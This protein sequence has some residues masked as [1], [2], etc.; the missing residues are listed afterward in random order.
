[1]KKNEW[2]LYDTLGF[3]NFT[4]YELKAMRVCRGFTLAQAAKQ[5]DCPR[6]V[7]ESFENCRIKK[8]PEFIVDRCI[9]KLG[10]QKNHITQIRKILKGELNSFTENR[11]IPTSIKEK[12][13]EQYGNK[14]A[15]CGSEKSLH[16][17]HKEHYADGG[18]NT[19]DNLILLCAS[20]HAKQHKGETPYFLLKAIAKEDKQ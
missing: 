2:Q 6:S 20:C 14:C 13:R 8:V 18:Q 7:L 15:L 4:G 9:H 5:M 1:M 16:F 11:N 12:V 3:H 10:V 17:H 19:A